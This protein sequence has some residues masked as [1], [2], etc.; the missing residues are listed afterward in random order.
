MVLKTMIPKTM[1]P[2]AQLRINMTDCQNDAN[3]R[4]KRYQGALEM[5]AFC[6]SHG[7]T[8]L[9]VEEH[10]CANNGWLSSPLTMA[11]AIAACT[12]HAR[13]GVS[14]L[15]VTL[16]DPIRL[17]EDIAV[18][19]LISN[20]RF[21]FIAGMGYR[22]IEFYALD[23]PW[24]TR[25]QW[26]DHVIG[27]LLNCWADKPFEYNGQIVN[28]TPKPLTV[29]HPPF[30]IGGMSKRAAKRAAR[31]G[32]DFAPPAK[33]PELEAF[34]HEQ[35]KI[36]GTTGTVV[37]PGEDFSVLFIDENPESAW[38][39]LGDYLLNEANEYASWKKDGL[40]RPLENAQ[41]SIEDLRKQKLYE[42][43][44]PEECLTR[45]KNNNN[46]NAVL[47]PLCGGIPID[48]AW[49]CLHL[50]VERVLKP[51]TD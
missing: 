5:A 18:I 30:L 31:F 4:A 36:H 39:E 34:Y 42:I 44:T 24:E 21:Y 22:P 40:Y 6:D 47:H 19:D 29:P 14:A 17:A 45:F 12:Q 48:R 49:N 37:S 43:I 20:G 9:N 25:G 7:F 28:V 51:L 27:T 23:K 1:I 15:L 32:L 46:F 33:L 16:Y 8:G 10:H 26:M 38:H 35:Q 41:N 13:I 2:N 11:S 3:V 50:F